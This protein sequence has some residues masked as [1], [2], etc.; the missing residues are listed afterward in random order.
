MEKI[1]FESEWSRFESFFD[2]NLSNRQNNVRSLQN[3]VIWKI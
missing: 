3:N 2:Q 1:W